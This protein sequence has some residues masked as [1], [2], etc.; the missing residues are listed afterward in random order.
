MYYPVSELNTDVTVHT[1]R[2]STFFFLEQEAL[3]TISS[4]SKKKT[5]HADYIKI[6]DL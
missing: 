1:T 4:I 3:L 2:K 6:S 5:I